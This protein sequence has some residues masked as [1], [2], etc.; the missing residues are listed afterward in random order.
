MHALSLQRWE[1]SA[2]HRCDEHARPPSA[3]V[4]TSHV[5][6]NG[7]TTMRMPRKQAGFTLLELMIVVAIIAILSAIA[8]PQYSQYITRSKL[9]DAMNGLSGYRVSMEQ[10]Y[11]DNRVYA[12]QNPGPALPT[13]LYFSFTCAVAADANGNAAQTYLVTA[14]GNAN[15]PVANFVYTINQLNTRMTVSTATGWGGA[16]SGCWTSNKGGC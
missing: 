11:Q 13:S 15:T 8:I 2:A 7:M 10:Y 12:C 6:G 5:Q 1:N 16:Q 9:T 14:T 3:F 4:T